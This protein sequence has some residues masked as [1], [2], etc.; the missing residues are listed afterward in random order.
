[1]STFDG[2]VA[3]FPEIR[4]DYFR[5]SIGKKVL[6]YFLSHVHSDH[7]QGLDT[8]RSQFIYCSSATRELLLR[9]EKFYHRVNFANK[10]TEVQVRGYKHLKN[11]LKPIPLNVPTEIELEPGKQVQ[12]TLLDANHCL[13]AV[14]FLIEGDG[15]AILY[16]GDIRAEAYWVNALA[17]N[18]IMVPYTRTQRHLDKIYLDTTFASHQDDCA[19]Y[20]T[21]AE[22]LHEL[23]AKVEIYPPETIFHFNAWTLGYEDVLVTLSRALRSKIHVDNYRYGLYRAVSK[24]AKENFS[25]IDAAALCGFQ[26]GNRYQNGCLTVDHS[27]RVHSCEKA[28]R[29]PTLQH[30]NVVWITPILKRTAKGTIPEIG[31]GGGIGSLSHPLEVEIVGD[32]KSSDHWINSIAGLITDPISCEKAITLVRDAIQSNEILYLNDFEGEVDLESDPEATF[33]FIVRALAKMS[34]L[35]KPNRKLESAEHQDCT[36][37]IFKGHAFAESH[38]LPRNITFPFSRHSSFDELRHLVEVFRPKDIFPCTVEE[39]LWTL[40][41][42]ME[43]LFGDLCSDKTFSH[44]KT[45]H[46]IWKNM[47][48]EAHGSQTD[49][50]ENDT[51]ENEPDDVDLVISSMS[52]DVFDG[53]AKLPKEGSIYD[54]APQSYTNSDSSPKLHMKKRKRNSPNDSPTGD[55]KVPQSSRLSTGNSTYVNRVSRM[56]QHAEA[57]SSQLRSSPNIFLQSSHTERSLPQL[58]GLDDSTFVSSPTVIPGAVHE[59]LDKASNGDERLQPTEHDE[60]RLSIDTSAFDSQDALFYRSDHDREQRV[61]PRK[62]VYKSLQADEDDTWP[63]PYTSFPQPARSTYQVPEEELG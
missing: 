14:M 3:E 20:V 50:S 34:M 43:N 56:M 6:A 57:G 10:R 13:G 59:D 40:E 30:P 37:T 61:L 16:T 53:V 60:S 8:F 58:D 52:D 49:Q 32:A 35:K 15:K 23:M 28:V 47:K 27:V 31:A 1:M 18:P 19:Q 2:V 7:T 42:S 39:D 24:A 12:V 4:I 46:S 54:T 9:M 25:A 22:G 55:L 62:S 33:A 21:K 44:D 48:V 38:E 26:C 29:C 11:L 63:P 41:H 36:P 17:R 51:T 45:M 5:R